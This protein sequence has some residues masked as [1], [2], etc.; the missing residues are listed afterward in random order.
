MWREMKM[1]DGREVCFR[2]TGP[3][4]G[5]LLDRVWFF[6]QRWEK[7]QNEALKNKSFIDMKNLTLSVFHVDGINSDH[8]THYFQGQFLVP[9][10]E[11][12]PHNLVPF[13]RCEHQIKQSPFMHIRLAVWNITSV[14]S[15]N[16]LTRIDVIHY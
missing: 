16:S 10:S 15:C 14:W 4:A 7:A 9:S 3:D 11:H 13:A 1:K 2:S 8:V 12:N 6:Q 5:L